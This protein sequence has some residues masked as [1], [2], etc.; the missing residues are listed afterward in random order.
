MA[1]KGNLR[2]FSFSQLLNLINIAKKTGTLIINGPNKDAWIS[3]QDGKLSYAHNNSTDGSLAAIL[4][5]YNK[6]TKK[7]YQIIKQR[8][9]NIGDKE[10]GLMLINANYLSQQEIL[11]SLKN[12]FVDTT[13]DVFTWGEGLFQFRNDR[14]PDPQKISLRINLENIIIEG[15]R[16]L[17]ELER[18]QDEIPSLEMALRFTDNPGTNIRNVN[19]SVKEWRVVSFINPKNTMRQIANRTKMNDLEFRRIVYS[20]LQAG[21]VQIVRPEGRPSPAPQAPS[22]PVEGK[23]EQKTLVN[24]IIKRIRSL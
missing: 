3:F 2:D 5:K 21:L 19:L 7:Q 11:S 1:L 6:L 17:K 20:L 24:R 14:L 16:R 10:L 12:A 4:Y 18:L 13:N 22:L 15:S 23:D 9:G 8:A